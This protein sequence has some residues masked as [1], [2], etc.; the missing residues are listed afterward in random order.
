MPDVRVKGA[1]SISNGS[2]SFLRTLFNSSVMPE[3]PRVSTVALARED[4]S[5]IQLA[6]SSISE[7]EQ[8]TN[9]KRSFRR[10]RFRD[11]YVYV[12]YGT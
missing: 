1:A 8:E 12:R 3:T 9:R 2:G 5:S 4:S 7:Y 6:N 10:K 11:T